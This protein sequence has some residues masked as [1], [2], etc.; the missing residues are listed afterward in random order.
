MSNFSRKKIYVDSENKVSLPNDTYF[1]HDLVGSKVFI[2][3]E[4]YGSLKD[5]LNM[6][7]NDIYVIHDA[8]N[9][10][11]LF[12][13]LKKYIKSFDADKKVLILEIEESFFDED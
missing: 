5:V 6:P 11:I 12:P 4:F 3:N 1:I 10:E 8:E 2:N 13:A 7:A 9:N